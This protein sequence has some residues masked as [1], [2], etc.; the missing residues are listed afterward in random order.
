MVHGERKRRSASAL[1]LSPVATSVAIWRSRSLRPYVSSRRGAACS[2]DARWITI[3]TRSDVVPSGSE[4]YSDSQPSSDGTCSATAASL[5]RLCRCW[6]AVATS[7]RIG[8]GTVVELPGLSWR[9]GSSRTWAGG[10]TSSTSLP[11]PSRIIPGAQFSSKRRAA[12]TRKDVRRAFRDRPR[13]PRDEPGVRSLEIPC[14]LGSVEHDAAPGATVG[15]ECGAHFEGR[16]A[17]GEDLPVPGAALGTSAGGFAEDADRRAPSGERGE[18]VV[19]VA[20]V[21]AREHGLG[22]ERFGLG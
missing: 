21:L 12:S 20:F 1:V 4:A 14:R 9:S 6:R 11:G 5:P 16:A 17:K 13:K 15:D 2:R 10:V 19:V 3:A 18:R 8:N 7:A 22:G